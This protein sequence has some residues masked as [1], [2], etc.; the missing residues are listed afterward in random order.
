MILKGR[1][2]G[3]TEVRVNVTNLD[4]FVHADGDSSVCVE[5]V[6]DEDGEP[7]EP[8]QQMIYKCDLYH[9]ELDAF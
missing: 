6:A 9:L 3:G 1:I 8:T 7:V 2:Y 5:V 4:E